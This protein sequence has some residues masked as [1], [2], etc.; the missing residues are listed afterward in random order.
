MLKNQMTPDLGIKDI[1]KIN[2]FQLSLKIFAISM[3]LAHSL[4]F[5]DIDTYYLCLYYNPKTQYE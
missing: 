1:I 4:S 5:K 3:I 2:C